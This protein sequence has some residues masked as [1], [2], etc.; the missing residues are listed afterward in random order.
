MLTKQMPRFK[1]EHSN[2][3]NILITN[4]RLMVL[5]LKLLSLSLPV[6]PVV[7]QGFPAVRYG[8]HT[9]FVLLLQNIIKFIN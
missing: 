2:M 9:A 3:A 8:S 4:N 5:L 7:N 1:N 6:P